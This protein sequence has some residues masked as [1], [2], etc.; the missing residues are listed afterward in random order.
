[1][2]FPWLLPALLLTA[3]TLPGSVFRQFE[4]SA[5]LQRLW[6]G[7]CKYP[8]EK[9]NLILIGHIR[10][11][12]GRPVLTCDWNRQ[13]SGTD[14]VTSDIEFPEE[15]SDIDGRWFACDDQ[16]AIAVWDA[17]RHP[18]SNMVHLGGGVDADAREAYVL[19][20][21][22]HYW[23]DNYCDGDDPNPHC[24]LPDRK[25]IMSVA[26]AVLNPETEEIHW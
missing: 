18:G 21:K 23:T 2:R 1:M 17:V 11:I 7:I 25:E 16:T 26:Y 24:S 3:C 14:Q 22:C 8:L 13:P 9:E 4:S 5:H 6:D 10:E 19:V 15:Q 12:D 20:G